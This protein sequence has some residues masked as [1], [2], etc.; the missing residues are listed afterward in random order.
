MLH[1]VRA[2]VPRL[3]VSIIRLALVINFNANDIDNI[4]SLY[5]LLSTAVAP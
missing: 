5:V 1:E 2:L 4:D 3:H